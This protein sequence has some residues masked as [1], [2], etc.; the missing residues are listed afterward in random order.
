M[1]WLDSVFSVPAIG[2]RLETN[3]ETAP[4]IQS[5]LVPFINSLYKNDKKIIIKTSE[6]WGYTLNIVGFIFTITYKEIIIQFNYNID[7]KKIAGS[8]PSIEYPDLKT[9]SELFNN[10]LKYLTDIL[11]YLKNID[12]FFNRIGI[13]ANANLD[14][15]SIPPGLQKAKEYFGKPWNNQLSN[16]NISITAELNNEDN[17]MDRCIH[18]IEFSKKNIQETGYI[19]SLD[20][21]RLFSEP[22]KISLALDNISECKNNAFEYFD[23]FG[24]GE[25]VYE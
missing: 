10:S 21:Q 25:I 17:Y 2:L 22:Q 8:L 13:V 7:E 5:S 4:Q 19:I 15:T 6:I 16:A 12:L 9:Y 24:I 20:W 1:F 18:K 11:S 23:K 14:D 3:Y